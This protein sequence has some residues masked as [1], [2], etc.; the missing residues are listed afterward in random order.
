MITLTHP[1][2]IRDHA[3]KEELDHL[4]VQLQA[5]LE[6]L[7]QLI[8]AVPDTVFG[9]PILLA[10]PP[11]QEMVNDRLWAVR[12]GLTPAIVIS[13]KAR[14]GGVTYTVASFGPV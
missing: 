11:I 14:V 3:T 7:A 4:V 5:E 9:I 1:E 6:R 13:V 8:A 12:E 10:D 2:L